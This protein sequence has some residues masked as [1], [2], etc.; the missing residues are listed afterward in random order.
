MTWAEAKAKSGVATTKS[1][2]G[3]NKQPPKKENHGKLLAAKVVAKAGPSQ[4]EIIEERQAA[5]RARKDQQRQ[6]QLEARRQAEKEQQRLEA[7]VKP[8]DLALEKLAELALQQ[9]EKNE[10]KS[11]QN[12]HEISLD[13]D[14]M[15]M[16]CEC[17]QMQM[18]E[19]TALE[20]IYADSDILVVNN[21][22]RCDDL[23]TILDDWQMDPDCEEF[24]LKLLKHPLLSFTL[25]RSLED[26][27]DDDAVAHI[28]MEVTFPNNYPM[29][30]TPPAISVVWFCLTQKSTVVANNKPLESVGQ[31]DDTA[32]LS[33]LTEKAQELLGMP[34]VYELLD[35]WLTD[36]LFSY[37][38]M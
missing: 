33:T 25:Q 28:L 11:I 26:P 18:D 8:Y 19:L 13:S 16:I 3:G 17:K 10:P 22:S 30:V 24:Q 21:S 14:R 32:L 23:R 12:S 37:I 34:A 27:N 4:A 36:N 7:V 29:E 31:L 6:E 15:Q 38:S 2:G 9:K 1:K 35:T 5:R 20:A